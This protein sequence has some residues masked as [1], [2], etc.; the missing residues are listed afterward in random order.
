MRPDGMT[1]PKDSVGSLPS[2]LSIPS[3]RQLYGAED[4]PNPGDIDRLADPGIVLQLHGCLRASYPA[5]VHPPPNQDLGDFLCCIATELSDGVLLT[6]P[7][8]RTHNP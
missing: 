6:L 4:G 5:L 2:L 1:V 3:P 8:C 7:L